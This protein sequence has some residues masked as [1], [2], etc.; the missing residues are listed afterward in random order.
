MKK[1]AVLAVSLAS[2]ILCV[3]S[4]TTLAPQW[5]EGEVI[6]RLKSQTPAGTRGL[7]NSIDSALSALGVSTMEPLLP[8]LSAAADTRRSSVS[9]SSVRAPYF[10][11]APLE[12]ETMA[13]VPQLFLLRFDTTLV[14][15]VPEAVRILNANADVEYAEPNYICRLE[16]PVPSFA[17]VA[18]DSQWGLRAIRMPELW[19]Q[20]LVNSR[21]PVIAFIDTGVDVNHPALRSNIS[22]E[23]YD[24]VD[25]TTVM[26]DPNGHGT[27]CAGIAAA[28]A[29]EVLSGAN[30]DAMI[31]P[32]RVVDEFG[33]GSTD[34]I[35]RGI[36]HAV[37]HGA[38][39]ISMSIGVKS[40]AYQEVV[41]SALEKAI[42]VASAGNSGVC[43]IES[44]RDLHGMGVDHEPN[45]PGAFPGVIGVMA[46]QQDGQLA[47]WSNF[48]CDGS[49]YDS[50]SS[51]YSYELRAPGT[52]IYSTL[53]GGTYGYMSGTSM[54][55]PLMAGAISRLMQCRTFNSRN[56]MVRTLV[57][58]SNNNVDIM[59][60]YKSE[61]TDL[62]PDTLQLI[63]D[64]VTFIFDR[65]G[66]ATLQLISATITGSSP[67]I[68]T[69]PDM[70]RGL[71]VT[72][73]GSSAFANFSSLRSL[74]L[75]S[76]IASISDG[77]LRD[78]TELSDIYFDSAEA[79]VAT[80]MALPS[81]AMR[82]ITLHPKRAHMRYFTTAPFWCRFTNWQDQ[83]L[84]TGNRFQAAISE[85]E[86]QLIFLIYSQ[87]AGIA[88]VG[89]ED[90]A[91]DRTIVGRMVLP[92]SVRGLDVRLISTFAFALCTR[93]KEVVFPSH[94]TYI[95]AYSFI[96]CDSLQ[97]LNLPYYTSHVGSMAFAG[98]TQ[99][100]TVRFNER[101]KS[102]SPYAFMGCPSLRTIV[103][104]MA[105]PPLIHDDTFRNAD[106]LDQVPADPAH[107]NDVY[108]NARLLVPYGCREL[109][110][111]ARGWRLFKNIVELSEDGRDLSAVSEPRADSKPRNSRGTFSLTGQRVSGNGARRGVYI[112]E[113]KKV[114][115]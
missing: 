52:D 14:A 57:M 31:M 7:C 45:F 38:D 92:D 113:G 108:D 29:T 58:T 84:V 97:E 91:V 94:L 42:L 63:T 95:D 17:P 89:A 105:T 21:R 26:T 22:Q 114:V 101:I 77:A 46:T 41:E 76:N 19:Q 28:A 115:F 56:D 53:P 111:E 68:V 88:Q 12:S 83:P 65:T 73:I 43:L 74:Y 96:Y 87:E 33:L 35:L 8:C 25:N 60:A 66:D 24:F 107:V 30:P 64:S 11:D 100:S 99:L 98:C 40:R 3:Y 4:Q 62:H 106:P 81:G 32:I 2:S 71:T 82:T 18:S 9:A 72:S 85:P 27:H 59:A 37:A 5:C 50:T 75:G 15:T 23:G 69:V 51:G 86:A 90:L 112:V 1:L 103:A 78:C 54:S 39:I 49:L 55:A 13:D 102:I 61:N 70:V 47:S 44:H 20:P 67:K 93:L 36:D 104:P 79:P 6:V 110:A 80:S 48:D 10:A 34:N 109:Y 16:S